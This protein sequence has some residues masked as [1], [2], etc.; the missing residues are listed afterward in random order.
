MAYVERAGLGPTFK[1]KLM[2]ATDGGTAAGVPVAT[3]TADSEAAPVANCYWI[4][5]EN[6][7][8][9]TIFVVGPGSAF[10][11]LGFEWP[12]ISAY[13][14]EGTLSAAQGEEEVCRFDMDGGGGDG[15]LRY[16]P[17]SAGTFRFRLSQV[18]G[19]NAYG[20]TFDTSTNYSLRFQFDGTNAKLWVNGI[21]DIS[22]AVSDKPTRFLHT[23]SALPTS[24]K[25]Y[26]CG[27]GWRGSNDEA[28]RND[29]SAPT[30]EG[31]NPKGDNESSDYGD[32]ADCT[33]ADGTWT[34]W[35]DD[36]S[37]DS[38]TAIFICIRGG[39]AGSE[40]SDM[41][42]ITMDDPDL[43]VL[44]QLGSAEIGSK[45]AATFCRIINDDGTPKISEV[46]HTNVAVTG[47]RGFSRA[48]PLDA[49]G[50]AWTKARVN[51]TNAGVRS[52][53]TNDDNDRWAMERMETFKWGNDPPSVEEEVSSAGGAMFA[54]DNMM[55][56]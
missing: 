13:R 23:S 2:L 35:D 47:W 51:A 6:G 27:L 42:D 41:D 54:S 20:S 24:P 30:I 37:D 39:S 49:N 12:V 45:T 56:V 9:G 1:E 50:D 53:D 11:A 38:N 52:L 4:R 48:F 29:P 8:S 10:T 5:E 44:R 28:D 21:L 40:T 43:V 22:I 36:G 33:T 14:L 34:D 55:V 19:N 17:L 15:R 31:S 16:D 32:D 18:G 25:Q 46:Q 3:T 26:W 7:D